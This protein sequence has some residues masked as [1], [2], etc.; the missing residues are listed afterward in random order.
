MYVCVKCAFLIA[1]F[2]PNISFPFTGTCIYPML[3]AN[4]TYT[5]IRGLHL[6]LH[7]RFWC[8]NSGHI[9][10]LGPL[11]NYD[12]PVI[13]VATAWGGFRHCTSTI[14]RVHGQNL[15]NEIYIDVS[16]QQ[17]KKTR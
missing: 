1:D 2:L 16:F 10:Y 7:T 13:L 9:H 11:T 5:G 15:G 17:G 6:F 14:I 4:D 8:V 3:L 12:T